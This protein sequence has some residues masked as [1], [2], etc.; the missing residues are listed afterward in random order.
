VVVAVGGKVGVGV[1]GG[2]MHEKLTAVAGWPQNA[3][4]LY[5]ATAR[6]QPPHTSVTALLALS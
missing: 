2:S 1:D 5:R 4:C 6:A 3:A